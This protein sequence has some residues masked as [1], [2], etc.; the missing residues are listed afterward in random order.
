[1]TKGMCTVEECS[2]SAF[3]S[4]LCSAHYARFKR[5]G[6]TQ[7][8][9]P[10]REWPTL[11][12]RFWSMVDQG[13][14]VPERRPDLGP[15]WLWTGGSREGYGKF[16]GNRSAHRF[17]YEL[18]VGPIPDGFQ[19]DH[20]CMVRACVNPSHLEPVTPL[21]NMRRM[22]LAYGSGRAAT[23]CPQGH[24]YDEENTYY[25]SNGRRCCRTCNRAAA[26]RH[27]DRKRA[28]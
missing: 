25:Y 3:A 12:V 20:L 4:G 6:D 23:H 18:A 22:H 10:V 27:R 26:R 8:D 13:G 11:E 14:P 16:T 24:P 28:S 15:C 1:M 17:A 9:V 19:I 21:E 2:R 7:P 5:Y